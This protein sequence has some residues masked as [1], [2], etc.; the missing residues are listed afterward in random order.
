MFTSSLQLMARRSLAHWKLLSAVVIGV[1]LA[2]S[3]M[4][5][6]VLYFD[7]L[8]N[9]A[10]QHDLQQQAPERLDILIEAKQSPVSRQAHEDIVSYVEPRLERG[11]GSISA[12]ITR[13]FKSNTFF[14]ANPGDEL[15]PLSDDRRRAS[16]VTVPGIED[17]ASLVS[18]G[19]P[20]R[21]LPATGDELLT[22]D[23]A[24]PV[25]VAEEYPPLTEEQV[26][27]AIA[28][29][30]ELTDEEDMTPLRSAALA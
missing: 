23:A 29:A 9:I 5:A 7:S 11:V 17:H 2:V 12:G 1:L 10:L 28:Y 22:V 30:A 16:C 6:T 19:W 26:R 3:I 14:L 8:R 18:G 13:A 25:E 27:A 20:N 4:S 21:T 15:P 24:I